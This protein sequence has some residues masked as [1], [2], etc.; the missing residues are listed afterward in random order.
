MF[1][2]VQR[3]EIK[4]KSVEDHRR[5]F[6]LRIDDMVDELYRL[7]DM[8]PKFE[9]PVYAGM[10]IEHDASGRLERIAKTATVLIEVIKIRGSECNE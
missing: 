4:Q 6:S 2:Q 8:A 1:N 3:E 9:S 10:G 7:H 5:D